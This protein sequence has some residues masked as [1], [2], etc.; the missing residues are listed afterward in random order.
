M[1]KAEPVRPLSRGGV[2]RGLLG[3]VALFLLAYLG[4]RPRIWELERRLGISS[5]ITAGLP[6]FLL[7]AVAHHPA[8]GVFSDAVLENIRPV[9]PFCLG[10]VAFSAGLRLDSRELDRAY[11]GS[12]AAATYGAL[13]PFF[14]V[15]A[16]CGLILWLHEPPLGLTAVVRD[17][18]M[19]GTAGAVTA[20]SA[21][22]FFDRWVGDPDRRERMQRIVVLE[23]LMG[24]G[25]LTAVVVMFRP[26][27]SETG[28]RLPETGWLFIV[29]GMGAFMGGLA[30]LL[31]RL[32]KPGAETTLAL[33]G[34]VLFASGMASYLRLSPMVVGAMAGALLIN[35]SGSRREEVRT[36]LLSMERP[37]YLV[38][39]IIAG[40]YWR[41]GE[42]EGWALAAVFIPARLA[43]KWLAVRLLRRHRA[44]F[45]A[46]EELGLYAAPMGAFSIALVVGAQDLALGPSVS[47]MVTAVVGSAIV[48]EAIV[49]ILLRRGQVRAGAAAEVALLEAA[50]RGMP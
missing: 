10:W 50:S 49:Q 45:T 33:L 30:A 11:P 35:L 42:W 28:W 32:V 16:C 29:L 13:V 48:I 21:T 15:A 7:G 39:L 4:G 12:L 14:S 46:A 47:W 34:T 9:L 19:L 27:A 1:R 18:M 38:F 24:L 6:L 22:V 40:A 2:I 31:L 8:V 36:A 26:A 44:D 20:L 25:L 37:I 43:A 3:C 5:V 41:P 23:V 17:A